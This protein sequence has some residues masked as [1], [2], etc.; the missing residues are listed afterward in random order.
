MR[1]PHRDN[2]SRLI[3]FQRQEREEF[4]KLERERE[5]V[6]L[7][8]IKLERDKAELLK[9]ER[10]T[11]A[12]ERDR[13]AGGYHDDKRGVRGSIGKRPHDDSY[14]EEKRYDDYRYALLNYK[15]LRDCALY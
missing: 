8:R 10:E 3:D 15:I 4:L 7:E 9:I 14:L 5:R 12:F 11:R 6:K 13:G 1:P 2:S